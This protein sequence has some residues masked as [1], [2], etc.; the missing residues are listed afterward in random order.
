MQRAV[1]KMMLVHSRNQ[2][3][4][5]TRILG[6]LLAACRLAQPA[7]KFALPVVPQF[8]AAHVR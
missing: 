7:Y 1:P 3:F 4:R 8:R 5:R 2:R 6:Y